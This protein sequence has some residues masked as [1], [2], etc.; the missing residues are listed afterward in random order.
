VIAFFAFAVSDYNL[1][2]LL[3][4]M[5]MWL[6]VTKPLLYAVLNVLRQVSH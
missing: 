2:A 3:T 6:L 1:V 5:V 4:G